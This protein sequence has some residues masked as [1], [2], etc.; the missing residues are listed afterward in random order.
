MTVIKKEKTS[1]NSVSLSWQQPERPNGIILDYEIKYY[2]K[3]GAGFLSADALFFPPVMNVSTT[4]GCWQ[5]K[6]KGDLGPACKRNLRHLFCDEVRPLLHRSRSQTRSF[7]PLHSLMETSFTAD[8]KCVCGVA[9]SSVREISAERIAAAFST[10]TGPRLT[11][12]GEISPSHTFNHPGRLGACVCA[13][14]AQIA[15]C[16]NANSGP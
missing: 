15:V 1:R 10:N 4:R 2:E 5:N 12:Y 7:P 11:F 13:W 14:T 16:L 6:I 3:V 8:S 9:H